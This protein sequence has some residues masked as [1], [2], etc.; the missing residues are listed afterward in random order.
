GKYQPQP[1]NTIYTLQP[2][3]GV[4]FTASQHATALNAIAAVQKLYINKHDIAVLDFFFEN[5]N[6]PTDNELALLTKT[7]QDYLPDFKFTLKKADANRPNSRKLTLFKMALKKFIVEGNKTM[8]LLRPNEDF[9]QFSIRP[10]PL[11]VSEN[12]GYNVI[13]LHFAEE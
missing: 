1:I 7:I 13:G 12:G 5:P 9:T 3:E 8:N 6:Q 4:K 11:G 10:E 2:R